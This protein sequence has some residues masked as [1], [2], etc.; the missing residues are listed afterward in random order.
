MIDIQD[1]AYDNDRREFTVKGKSNDDVKGFFDYYTTEQFG[2]P[3][4]EA[5]LVYHRNFPGGDHRF[6]IILKLAEDTDVKEFL[7]RLNDCVPDEDK[8][9]VTDTD[10]PY[11]G[12][13]AFVG[14][15]DEQLHVDL[16][17]KGIENDPSIDR[18]ILRNIEAA[19]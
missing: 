15:P 4:T 13:D 9:A 7:A 6:S 12:L 17:M 2:S 1:I 16:C 3:L 11:K 10:N 8:P 5:D 14:D 18:T 19:S